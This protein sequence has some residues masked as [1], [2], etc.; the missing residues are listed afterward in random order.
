MASILASGGVRIRSRMCGA[1]ITPQA[2]TVTDRPMK[3]TMAVP[4]TRLT[5][6]RLSAPTAWATRMLADMETPNTAPIISIMIRLALD[7]AAIADSPRVWLTQN[8]LT[9]PFSDCST[10]PPRTGRENITR[11]CRI[12]PSVRFRPPRIPGRPPIPG[13]P[14]PG[15]PIPGRP[16]PWAP[17]PGPPVPGPAWAGLIGPPGPGG[18]FASI[19]APPPAQPPNRGLN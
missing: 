13:G 6:A 18:D 2:A 3:K 15:G 17:M 10:L 1:K 11:V 4:M 5:R 7:R 12:G 16:M 14:M 9:V 8:W 19:P